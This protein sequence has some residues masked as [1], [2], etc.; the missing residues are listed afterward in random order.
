MNYLLI[1]WLAGGE[2]IKE[3]IVVSTDHEALQKADDV[4]ARL[5]KEQQIVR[6]RCLYRLVAEEW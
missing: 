2:S 6:H 3:D 5:L 1:V 4:I